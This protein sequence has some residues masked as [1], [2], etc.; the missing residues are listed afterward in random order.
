MRSRIVI[1]HLTFDALTA[2][3]KVTAGFG[4]GRCLALSVVLRVVV[5]R[6]CH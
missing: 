6:R 4:F 5:V 1:D 2:L 3:D